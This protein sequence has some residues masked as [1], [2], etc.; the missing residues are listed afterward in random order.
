[1]D[2]AKRLE[3]LESILGDHVQITKNDRDLAKFGFMAVFAKLTP[4]QMESLKEVLEMS[5]IAFKTLCS[6]PSLYSD[7]NLSKL[8]N[9]SWLIMDH[10]REV[11]YGKSKNNPELFALWDKYAKGI[12]L[13][14]K[15]REELMAPVIGK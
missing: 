6:D 12:P 11:W 4:D 8:G 9:K 14:W 15:S 13:V 10:V 2:L 7:K 1:M 5:S 3:R